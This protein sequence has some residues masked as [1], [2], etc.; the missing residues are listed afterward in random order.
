MIAAGVLR[1][2]KV[3]IVDD[4]PA[5]VALARAYL[6]STYELLEASDGPS[7]L[8]ILNREPVDLVLLDVMMPEMSGFEVCK[9][10]KQGREQYL[11][12]ILLT[13]L[14]RQE[15]RNVG[16]EAGADDFMSKPVDRRE[17]VLRVERLIK[18]KRHEE[19]IREQLELVSQHDEM[20]Q[21]QIRELQELDVLKDDLVAMM[22][23]DLRNPLA[24]I[25][26]FL[27]LLTSDIDDQRLRRDADAA[28]Q[29][30]NRLREILDDML[31]TR[32]LESGALHMQRELVQAGA[33]V[34]DAIK[35]VWGAARARRV[36]IAP[37]IEQSLPQLDADPKY[38]RR[39]IENLLTNAVKY[40][41]SGASVRASVRAVGSDVEIEV[42]DRGSGIPEQFK[43]H[44]FQKF[45]SIE[46][47][48]GEAR[49]GIGLGL[50]LVK[51]VANAHGGRAIVRDRKH[52]GAA[53]G[54]VLPRASPFPG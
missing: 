15:Q 27:D 54:L 16:L 12:V 20:A 42:A 11:P 50:Y 13:A 49:N 21:K 10:I 47:A 29:A 41:P 18:L 26:G 33:M 36:E 25:V 30:G 2:A 48:R 7:A 40:S 28:V 5:N 9:R 44:L 24:G 35:S 34:E 23:H 6:D 17:L 45:G 31:H 52:G 22:V 19:Q 14:D 8:A 32:M 37:Q 43:E 1:R 53:F 3:L 38:V 46:V 39:A 4:E 51:L